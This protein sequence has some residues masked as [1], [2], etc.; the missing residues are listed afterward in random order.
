[1][2]AELGEAGQDGRS[3]KTKL[4]AANKMIAELKAQLAA[5]V[6]SLTGGQHKLKPVKPNTSVLK[7]LDLSEF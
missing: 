5:K 6:W 1:M 7:Y 4:D 2:I 3:C